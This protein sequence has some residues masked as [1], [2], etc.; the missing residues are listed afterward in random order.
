MS[1]LWGILSGLGSLLSMWRVMRLVRGGAQHR[2]AAPSTQE[3]LNHLAARR[4]IENA[5]LPFGRGLATVERY[6]NGETDVIDFELELDYDLGLKQRPCGAPTLRGTP[7]TRDAGWGTTHKGSGRCA[8]HEAHISAPQHDPFSDLRYID[9]PWPAGSGV[10]HASAGHLA[11][12]N[13]LP[14]Y[15]ERQAFPLP[16]QAGRMPTLAEIHALQRY[17]EHDEPER[18]YGPLL[19]VDEIESRAL[20]AAFADTIAGAGAFGAPLPVQ[21]VNRPPKPI[22][23]RESAIPPGAARVGLIGVPRPG[24]SGSCEYGGCDQ[25]CIARNRPGMGTEGERR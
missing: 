22:D 5:D 18:R 21:R 19:S 20:K 12:A 13:G 3:G 1:W 4:A 15:H 16:Q 10:P 17:P 25:F 23:A 8:Q 24:C 2:L 6:L 11:P 9:Y 14:Y 7:C